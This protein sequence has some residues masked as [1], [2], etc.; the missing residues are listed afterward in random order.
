[1][2]LFDSESDQ[3]GNLW[4]TGCSSLN[5]FYVLDYHSWAVGFWVPLCLAPSNGL[6]SGRLGLAALL[7]LPQ[8]LHLFVF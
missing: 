1:M 4:E 5:G 2:D 7:R 8:L 3:S 6:F